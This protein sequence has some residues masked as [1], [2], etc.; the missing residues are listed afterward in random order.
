MSER[1]RDRYDSWKLAVPDDEDDD[2][3]RDL[4]AEREAAAEER[5][6]RMRE[7]QMFDRDGR[8]EW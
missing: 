5:A 1:W 6:E 4:E 8:D 7:D 2:D 3:G